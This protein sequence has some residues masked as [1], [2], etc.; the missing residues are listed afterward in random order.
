MHLGPFCK[1][2]RNA[3]PERNSRSQ[4]T[5]IPPLISILFLTYLNCLKVLKK[6]YNNASMTATGHIEGKS[7]GYKLVDYC[8]LNEVIKRVN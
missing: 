2:F 7:P 1:G 5:E 4:S 8:K 6:I 3:D